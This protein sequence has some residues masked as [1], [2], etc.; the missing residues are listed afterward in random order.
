MGGRHSESACY[1]YFVISTPLMNQ[2]LGSLVM[3]AVDGPNA[4]RDDLEVGQLAAVD[5]LL[6][7]RPFS[8]RGRPNC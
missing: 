4:L 7:R 6:P 3:A 1:F 8:C 2:P 5:A